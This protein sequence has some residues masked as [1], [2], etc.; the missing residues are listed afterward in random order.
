[1]GGFIGQQSVYWFGGEGALGFCARSFRSFSV[2]GARDDNG[3]FVATHACMRHLA[4]GARCGR[5]PG[6][7]GAAGWFVLRTR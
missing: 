2:L 1:M 3:A 4:G 6:T 5:S 7:D